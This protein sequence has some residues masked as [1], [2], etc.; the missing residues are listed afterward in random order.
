MS[1]EG[2]IK[3]NMYA[4]DQLQTALEEQNSGTYLEE[5]NYVMEINS[6]ISVASEWIIRNGLR[7]YSE[8]LKAES[9]DKDAQWMKS[10]G[11]LYVPWQARPLSRMLAILEVAIFEAC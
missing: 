4:I 3:G 5:E 7:L 11:P 2:L 6:T 9:L 1:R 8:G 10:T